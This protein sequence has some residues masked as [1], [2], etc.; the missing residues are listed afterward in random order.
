MYPTILYKYLTIP[1]CAHNKAQPSLYCNLTTTTMWRSKKQKADPDEAVV[2]KVVG[3]EK[4]AAVVVEE[5]AT[6]AESPEKRTS[7]SLL[8]RYWNKASK[9][10]SSNDVA[11]AAATEVEATDPETKD[12]A[13][14]DKEG[15]VVQPKSRWSSLWNR[16]SRNSHQ[17][18]DTDDEA[19]NNNDESNNANDNIEVEITPETQKL[20]IHGD[21]NIGSPQHLLVPL[22]FAPSPDR[23]SVHDEALEMLTGSLLIYIFADLRD[24]ARD[25]IIDQ[26]DLLQDP[27]ALHQVAKAIENNK[28]ALAERAIEHEVI[29][30][31]MQ[32]LR[33]I[34][35][36][37]QQQQQQQQAQAPTH[38]QQVLQGGAVAKEAGLKPS[39]ESVLAQ[40]HD[41]KTTQ[42]VVYGIAVNHLRKRVTIIFRGSVTQQ[43]FITDAKSKM[44]KIDNPVAT[45]DS[46][47]ESHIKIHT[48]FHQYLFRKDNE[49]KERI[50]HILDSAKE[51]LKENPGYR[52]YCTG[53][54]LGGACCTLC[55]FYAAM[56]DEIVKY[57]PV[58]V[59]SIA[60]PR[61]GGHEFCDAFHSLE[62][63]NRLQHLRVANKEDVVTH[64]PFISL[65]A[66][67]M[68]P[69]LSAIRGAGN[70]YRHCGINLEL[71]SM[72]LEEEAKAEDKD[73]EKK[74]EKKATK[75]ESPKH[76]RICHPKGRCLERGAGSGSFYSDYSTNFKGALETA[77]NLAESLAPVRNADFDSLTE[78]HSCTEYETR[79]VGA[80]DYLSTITLDQLYQDASIVG[81]SFSERG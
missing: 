6:P 47:S 25:G 39:K 19:G 65:K 75:E 15:D 13:S 70:I 52:L 30:E 80:K 53:H 21:K 45:L 12:E 28:E 29:G 78:Y 64:L 55:G 56:D 44:F 27:I 9:E 77:K 37:Q 46:K 73:E 34:H 63:L 35:T 22:S 41:E 8:H 67:A 81:K 61:V 79:L 60:S 20:K 4:T 23:P 14:K 49:G 74:A 72:L 5:P 40:F 16:S 33:D 48:G 32:A 54:S 71:R 2:E 10:S 50:Q 68:S 59:I 42:G 62:L 26:S 58:V 69:L 38:L 43:D 51:L 76:Y 3:D 66:T 36:Q 31:K 11:A 24:M 57:G 1:Y 7:S 18:F 17:K